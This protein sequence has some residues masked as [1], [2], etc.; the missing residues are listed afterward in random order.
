[1]VQ[2]DTFQF[3]ERVLRPY[4]HDGHDR[5]RNRLVA[6]VDPEDHDDVPSLK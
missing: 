2:W 6:E 1:M 3:E 4:T 5:A